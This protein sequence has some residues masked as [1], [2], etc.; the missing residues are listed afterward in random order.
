MPGA[1]ID[2]VGQ[3]PFCESRHSGQDADQPFVAVRER[4]QLIHPRARRQAM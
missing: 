4:R 3:Q 2:V 1:V